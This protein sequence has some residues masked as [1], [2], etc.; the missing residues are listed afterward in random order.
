M[1]EQEAIPF[2]S[3]IIPTRN[4]P[5]LFSRALQSVLAQSSEAFELITV[6][7]GSDETSMDAYHHIEALADPRVTVVELRRRERGHGPS[8][9]IN[10]GAERARGRY[11]CV[12]DDDDEWTDDQH[13]ANVQQWI[14]DSQKT[15]DAVYTNQH[16]FNPD[17]SQVPLKLWIN[18]LAEHY[19]GR[20]GAHSVTAGTLLAAGGFPHLNCT[21]I[22]RE[23]F[24]EIGGFD[25][26]IRYE[27]EVDLYF[28]TLDAASLILY[29]PAFIAR[30]HVPAGSDRDSESTRVD[31]V[32]KRLSQ[33]HVYTKN[34][35][36]ARSSVV[37][38]TAR[39]RLGDVYR[40]L[41]R[42]FAA[43]GELKRSHAFA[44]QAQACRPT[45]RWALNTL[46]LGL[47]ARLG[48]G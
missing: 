9:A 1:N 38:D 5:E 21:I 8:Y 17:G 25:D 45:L 42:D 4:R 34:L 46:L 6:N 26:G 19:E 7:D 36:L 24:E 30:H 47:R 22:R 18:G 13:L 10:T 31:A 39:Q 44:R 14:A 16:A 12:L 40:H 32:R 29:A 33:S 11:L 43:N 2:F 27:T 23:L 15:V 28:R 20:P 37:R 41:S 35:L 48:G 3:V